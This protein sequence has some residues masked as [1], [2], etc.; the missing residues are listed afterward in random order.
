MNCKRSNFFDSASRNYFSKYTWLA[1]THSLS[2]LYR[3][4]II[5]PLLNLAKLKV[6]TGLSKNK[7][8]LF[9]LWQEYQVF[10]SHRHIL[11]YVVI[12]N[13]ADH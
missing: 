1:P 7:I 8:F 10:R 9:L 3:T 13:Y 5:L 12:S 2:L 4:P 6:A 11:L